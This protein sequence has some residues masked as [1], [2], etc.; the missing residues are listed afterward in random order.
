MIDSKS[1]SVLRTSFRKRKMYYTKGSPKESFQF[2]KSRNVKPISEIQ[3][4]MERMD[5]LT[6]ISEANEEVSRMK[7]YSSED[8]LEIVRKKIRK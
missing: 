1:L 8:A 6:D 2:D 3:A 7:Y 5:T 4:I